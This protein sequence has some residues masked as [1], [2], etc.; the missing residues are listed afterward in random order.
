MSCKQTVRRT[1]AIAACLMMAGC[2][3]RGGP[4]AYNQTNF[5]PPDA[6]DPAQH[7][8]DYRLSPGDVVDVEVYELKTV[9]GNAT[10]DAAGNIRMPLIG[11][12][13]ANGLA[14]AQLRDLVAK[15]LEKYLQ[16]PHVAVSLVSAVERTVTVEGDVTTPG[17]YVIT[18][19]VTLIQALALAKGVTTASNC[20]ARHRVSSNRWPAR[21]CGIRSGRDPARKG[22]RP[23][24]LP[25]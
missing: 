17:V 19:D 13:T 24:Y 7:V 12:V 5:A 10:V 3:G 4:I 25:Q 2:G 21:S 18:P 22:G 16:A 20:Q 14:V 15:K 8:T 23:A 6:P 9:S 1:T 11:P